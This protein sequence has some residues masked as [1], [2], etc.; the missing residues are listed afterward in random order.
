M[1]TTYFA[2]EQN[3]KRTR[4]KQQISKLKQRPLDYN[5][6]L[7]GKAKEIDTG[8]IFYFHFKDV[9]TI[10]D[11]NEIMPLYMITYKLER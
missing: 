5:E 1:I 6:R 2:K 3:A 4:N 9:A 7:T 10:N 8:K 11:T